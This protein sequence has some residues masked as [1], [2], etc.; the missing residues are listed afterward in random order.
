MLQNL[1]RIAV[2]SKS[3]IIIRKCVI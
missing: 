3:Y 2:P 1:G